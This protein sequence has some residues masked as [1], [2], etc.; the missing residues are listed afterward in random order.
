M[1]DAKTGEN[2]DKE[3]DNES[4]L[5]FTIMKILKLFFL[6][7]FSE[8]QKYYESLVCPLEPYDETNFV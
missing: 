8:F 5:Y 7:F 3:M 6:E 2:Q 1:N 4:W